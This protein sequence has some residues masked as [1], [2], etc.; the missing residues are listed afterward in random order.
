MSKKALPHGSVLRIVV[1]NESRDPPGAVKGARL[2]LEPE[3]S[4]DAAMAEVLA[5]CLEHFTANWPALR[6]TSA[7]ESIHQMRVALRRLRAAV[8]VFRRA[9][10]CDALETAAARA[11]NI[12]ATL[13]EARDWDVFRE[14]LDAL[15]A[16]LC[17]EPSYAALLEAAEARRRRGHQA[18]RRLIDEE[19]TTRFIADL[20]AALAERPW[21]GDDRLEKPG[22]AKKFAAKA[23]D[24]LH[25][26][27]G[28]GCEDL[29]ALSVEERHEARIAL[30]KLR[31]AAEFFE[32]LFEAP[33]PAKS[34]MKAVTAAQDGL[35][36]ENDMA[37]ATRLVHEIE[38]GENG[39]E[40]AHAAGFVQG[41]RAHAREEAA[42]RLG[43]VEKMVAGLEPFWR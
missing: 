2:N 34:Y 1:S 30:K 35:G 25:R 40:T 29:A 6:E 8:G 12:A 10:R 26:R 32:S 9:A 4:L 5:G 31:Y 13:G 18:A 28:R 11:K 38:R 36:A 3:V 37:V 21:R 7:P 16:P 24:R 42:Q 43:K 19:A 22:S 14:G 17:E 41:W 20:G 39:A 27:A 15:R 33:G 23:L